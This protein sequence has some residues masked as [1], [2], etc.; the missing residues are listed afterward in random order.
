MHDD[1]QNLYITSSDGYL[2]VYRKTQPHRL[3][4][5][6]ALS[7]FGLSS[8]IASGNN[9]FTGKGF[10]HS[11]FDNNFLYLWALNEGDVGLKV[12]KS[13]LTPKLT[14]GDILEENTTAIF[15]RNEP[16][17]ISRRPI[18]VSHAAIADSVNC[19]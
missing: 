4:R 9:V 3:I 19:S 18:I 17:R 15:D 5:K 6:V 1:E 7:N 14:Y 16:S 13:T 12:G 11:A 10:A 8:I 2:R